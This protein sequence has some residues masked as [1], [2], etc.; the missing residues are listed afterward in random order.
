MIIRVI[1]AGGSFKDVLVATGIADYIADMTGVGFESDH[2][3]EVD[4]R[5]P[6]YCIGLCHGC[7]YDC[8]GYCCTARGSQWGISRTDGSCDG[9]WFHRIQSR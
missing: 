7:S 6:A 3:R 2:P 8:R 4:G 5:N 1:G 9:V